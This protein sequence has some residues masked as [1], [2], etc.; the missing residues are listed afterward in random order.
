MKPVLL[1]YSDGKTM[2]ARISVADNHNYLNEKKGF[3]EFCGLL[4]G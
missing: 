3:G 2:S 1:I 4:K